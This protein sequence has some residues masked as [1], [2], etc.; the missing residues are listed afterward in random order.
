MCS[1]L[2]FV[3]GLRVGGGPAGFPTANFRLSFRFEIRPG[4]GSFDHGPTDPK[5]SKKKVIT[6][7]SRKKGLH[8]QNLSRAFARASARATASVSQSVS[9]RSLRAHHTTVSKDG[10]APLGQHVRL[11]SRCS[12]GGWRGGW[13][14]IFPSSAQGAAAAGRAY[15]SVWQ[16]DKK[17]YLGEGGQA[18]F[19]QPLRPRLIHACTLLSSSR[20]TRS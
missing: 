12:N 13:G 15:T 2:F 1:G 10:S 9:P 19:W 11:P 20:F 6:K 3:R 18:G 4:G 7:V 17:V 8:R 5:E 14:R 16:D